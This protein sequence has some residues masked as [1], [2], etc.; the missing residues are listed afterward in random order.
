MVC[1][2]VYVEAGFK[3]SEREHEF[4]ILLDERVERSN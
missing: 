3:D 1:A 2:S 4:L